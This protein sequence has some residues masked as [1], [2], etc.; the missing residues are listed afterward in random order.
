LRLTPGSAEGVPRS[1]QAIRGFDLLSGS[2]G[3]GALWPTQIVIESR[4]SAPVRAATTRL[5]ARLH[6]DPE[7][8]ETAPPLTDA[9]GAFQELVVVGRHEYGNAPAHASS[10]AAGRRKAST[11]ST[12]PTNTFRGSCSQCC[13][14]RICCSCARSGRSSC[15]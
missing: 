7:V 5:V 15:R 9:S 2:L 12:A 8:E 6:A 4:D 14:S 1:P 3:P 13:C 10:S 11:S